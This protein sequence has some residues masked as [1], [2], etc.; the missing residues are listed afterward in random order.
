MYVAPSDMIFIYCNWDS[1]RW[2]WSVNLQKNRNGT[3][4]NEK[5]KNTQNNKNTQNTQIR[6]Q[7]FKIR[8]QA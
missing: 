6:K 7:T 8:K 1:T 2:Q 3:A 4:V 5:R